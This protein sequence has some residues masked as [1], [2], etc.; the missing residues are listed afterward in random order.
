MCCI[1]TCC[2]WMVDLIQRLWGFA[3]AC[4]ISSAVCCAMIV[5]SMAGIALGYNYS[6]A[7]YIDL[8]E[9]NVSLYMRRGIFDDE[10]ADLD[11]RR[12]GRKLE[13]HLASDNLITAPPE[14]DTTPLRSGRR[15]EDSV[16]E[17]GDQNKYEGSLMRLT[18]K[19]PFISTHAPIITGDDEMVAAIKNHPEGSLEA[20]KEVQSLIDAR[21]AMVNKIQSGTTNS[22]VPT[23]PFMEPEKAYHS[24]LSRRRMENQLNYKPEMSDARK[25][26]PDVINA[27][28][29]WLFPHH[30]QAFQ[31]QFD[32]FGLA[33]EK[34]TF[35]S[36]MTLRGPLRPTPTAMSPDGDVLF[37]TPRVPLT[38]FSTAST[39]P[40]EERP[41]T[42]ESVES[43]R[44]RLGLNT[45]AAPTK[46][47]PKS[48]DDY[49]YEVKGL[50]VRKRRSIETNDEDINDVPLKINIKTIERNKMKEVLKKLHPDSMD[51]DEEHTTLKASRKSKKTFIPFIYTVKFDDSKKVSTAVRRLSKKRN[52]LSIELVTMKMTEH[53]EHE[54][55]TLAYLDPKTETTEITERTTTTEMI[56]IPES[57]EITEKPTTNNMF[58]PLILKLESIQNLFID[59][60]DNYYQPSPTSNVVLIENFI[61]IA[62]TK[63]SVL[64]CKLAGN[65]HDKPSTEEPIL[66][67]KP[68]RKD[69]PTLSVFAKFL[70]KSA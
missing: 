5:A 49:D 39:E 67:N 27:P 29:Q 53:K 19:A 30:P 1:F 48:D 60:M 11:W 9:T 16:F 41:A 20:L 52:T 46:Y 12:S 58:G 42:K 23:Y 13:G 40:T 43:F 54:G 56:E 7:E 37:L 45:F 66:N 65:N 34:I 70:S 44:D 28:V 33:G 38:L 6:L 68:K 59:A 26:V 35:P 22:P 18:A 63:C 8:K 14:E 61:D 32:E 36:P 21:R 62:P 51:S 25:A 69:I 47:K 24:D 10:I 3:M 17:S 50:P 64:L 4:C 55:E 31:R 15:L 57:L 2:G